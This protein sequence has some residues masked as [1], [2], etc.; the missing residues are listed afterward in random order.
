MSRR[1]YRYADRLECGPPGSISHPIKKVY[2]ANSTIC[3]RAPFPR[4]L[5]L[6]VSSKTLEGAV[7]FLG[8]LLTLD[9]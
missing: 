6:E 5:Q 7:Y 4:T 1:K 3:T 2:S 8:K 9:V